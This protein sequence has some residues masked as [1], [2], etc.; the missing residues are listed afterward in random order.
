VDWLSEKQWG[1]LN[2]LDKLPSFH[3]FLEHFGKEFN[4]YRKMY[5]SSTPQDFEL[6]AQWKHLDRLQFM[7]I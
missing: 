1:E 7:C 3:G 5:D 2:R 6:P 4:Y